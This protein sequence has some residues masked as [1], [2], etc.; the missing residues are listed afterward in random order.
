DYDIT[1][2][3][4]RPGL[5]GDPPVQTLFLDFGGE[6]INTG[7]WGG[8]G[9]R[10]L[11]PLRAF[12]GRWGLTN[13][14]RDPLI[15]EIVATTRENIR[16]DLRASGLNRDFRIRI[17][18][19]RDDADPF[20]D[21]HVSR[22]IVG[23][24]IAESGIE[25][26]GIAQS[27][28]PGNFGTE[29]SALVLLD[30]LSDPAGE[31]EDPSLNTY[32]TPASDRVAF[33]GQAVGNIVAHEAGHFFGNW[34][35]DQ[36]NDQANLMDQGGNFPVLYGVGPDEVGGTADDVDVDFGED[37]FNPSEGFTGAEDTLKR[38]VFALRR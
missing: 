12:L 8:P 33:I 28:D 37:A 32:I 35:V 17:L 16:R 1:V 6:R 2:E 14:D 23:G 36:F 4:Y 38:I 31:F 27:I 21:D 18:N 11:S 13:A 26:I 5:E 20:G 3:V 15:D 24:T 22:V 10:T 34:H 9:V 7:I 30:I 19:S 29:E 25:T